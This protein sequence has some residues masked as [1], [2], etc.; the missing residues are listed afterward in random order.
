VTVSVMVLGFPVGILLV[1]S[2][3]FLQENP[4]HNVELGAGCGVL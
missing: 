1:T 4:M 3:Q 2:A